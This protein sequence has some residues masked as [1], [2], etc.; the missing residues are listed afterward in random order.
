MTAFEQILSDTLSELG[1]PCGAREL[2]LCSRYWEHLKDRQQNL[3]LTAISDDAEAAVKH[4]ADSA[5]LL[6]FDVIPANATLIDVGSGNG[7]PGLALKLLRPDLTVTL[8][9]SLEKRC[10]FLEESIALLDLNGITVICAR[11]EEA[12]RRPELRESF[13]LAVARAVAALPVLLE[14]ALPFV[15]CGGSFFALKGAHAADELAE[16]DAALAILGGKLAAC[17]SYDLPRAGGSRALLCIDKTQPTPAKYPRRPG[18][19]A[20]RPLRV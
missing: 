8:L 7:F 9:D 15:R 16:S 1:V 2:E 18:L 13:D 14:Y 11:A 17:H 10:R 6:R 3:N 20:K 4:F 19:P 5:A 12:G